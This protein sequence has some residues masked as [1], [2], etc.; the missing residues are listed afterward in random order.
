MLLQDMFRLPINRDV[1][2]M[3]MV[4]R[5]DAQKG[6]DLVV[7]V[8]DEFLKDDIQFV[9]LGTGE[10]Q[11]EHALMNAAYRHPD[12]MSVHLTFDEGL[13]RKIYAASDLFLMPSLYEP[14][15]ISQFIAFRYG[16]VPIVRETGGLRDVVQPYNEY[17]G[18]GN[19]FSFSN[20]NAHDMLY[21][22]R[23]AVRFFHD[24]KAWN[25]ILNNINQKDYSWYQSAKQYAQLYQQLLQ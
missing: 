21:T 11:Y 13:S 6:I 4:T 8:M 9:V 1:P 10:H 5:L 24:K 17:T 7:R 25:K 3:S 19:G 16:A 23:R 18:E 14:C 22:I 20:Y 15:G 2:F 12:K